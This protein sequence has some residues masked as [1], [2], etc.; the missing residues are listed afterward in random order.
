MKYLDAK[1]V[2]SK[3]KD[4]GIVNFNDAK[5]EGILVNLGKSGH[6][7]GRVENLKEYMSGLS[8]KSLAEDTD[9][10]VWVYIANVRKYDLSV[11]LSYLLPICKSL[12]LCSQVCSHS[13]T[14]VS[15]IVCEKSIKNDIYLNGISSPLEVPY[16]P[17]YGG[18]QFLL[19]VE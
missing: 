18:N 15:I 4:V 7:N 10:L 8:F 19:K 6:L 9:F 5:K 16:S 13:N 3:I 2:I 12:S 11:V 17:I 14:D 1:R